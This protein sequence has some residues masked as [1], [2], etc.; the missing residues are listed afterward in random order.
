M[1]V[2]LL[3]LRELRRSPA[4][5][6]VLVSAVALLTL[7]IV[8]QQTFLTGLLGQA[9]GGVRSADADLYVLSEAADAAIPASAVPDAAVAQARAVDGVADAGP[10]RLGFATATLTLLR[11]VGVSGRV[12]VAALAAQVTVAV[13][14]GIGVG[15]LAA[16][17]AI[18]G[19]DAGFEIAIS[20]SATAISATSILTLGLVAAAAAARRILRLDPAAA[21]AGGGR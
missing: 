15:V 4:R 2:R 9:N 7:L 8:L 13:T 12:L 11:A 16:A 6:A 5:F 1:T 17:V 20:A 21:L 18:G 3:A 14:A 10:V 19:I